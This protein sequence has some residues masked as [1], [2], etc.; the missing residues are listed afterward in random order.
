M[1]VT[2][3]TR[4]STNENVCTAVIDVNT[5][6]CLRPRPYLKWERCKELGIHAGAI[7]TGDLNFIKNPPRPHIEDSN[8]SKLTYHGSCDGDKFKKI[9][10]RSL[11]K[12]LSDGF[13]I[14]FT[15]DQKHI[16]TNQ[17]ANCSIVTIMVKPYNLNIHE[18]QY[19]PGK[20]KASFIDNSGHEF[21]YLSITDLGFHDYAKKHQ[22][23]GELYKVIN[24]IASQDE[25][26][27][28]IGLSRAFQSPDGRYGYWLQVNGIYT[29]PYFY[30]SIRHYE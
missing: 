23:D 19:K 13:G 21:R 29:F 28:R 4:F 15:L 1:I 26:Y 27:L 14:P 17:V 3:L 24:F 5:G 7:L 18:D 9:L 8:Y 2:D 25:V 22:N 10:D 6:E 11:C 30:Q 12:S 20:I 16:P